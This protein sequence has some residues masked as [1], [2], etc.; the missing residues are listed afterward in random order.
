MGRRTPSNKGPCVTPGRPAGGANVVG[1]FDASAVPASSAAVSAGRHLLLYCNSYCNTPHHS[2]RCS[3]RHF[4]MRQSRTVTEFWLTTWSGVRLK[5]SVYYIG[6]RCTELRT[7]DGRD[8]PAGRRFGLRIGF[9]HPTLAVD[10]F[11]AHGLR[12]LLG[13]DYRRSIRLPSKL[14]HACGRSSMTTR[15]CRANTAASRPA[16]VQNCG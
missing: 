10:R 7:E 15:S 13:A 4:G 3:A 12:V 14:F 2:D 5:S 8:L 9:S 16:I 1:R 6:I 11:V